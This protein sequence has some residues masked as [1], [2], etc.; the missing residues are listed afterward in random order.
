[1]FWL[2]KHSAFYSPSLDIILIAEVKRFVSDLGTYQSIDTSDRGP[3]YCVCMFLWPGKEK[4]KEKKK[5][6]KE[7]DWEGVRNLWISSLMWTR[8]EWP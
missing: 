7:R 2:R 4:R 6:E 3:A 1:M 8:A 5:R